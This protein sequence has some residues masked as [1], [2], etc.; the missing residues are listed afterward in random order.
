MFNIFFNT[1]RTAHDPRDRMLAE[2]AD[3]IFEAIQD[4]NLTSHTNGAGGRCV[5][6]PAQYQ[7][8]FYYILSKLSFNL[9]P[10]V[11]DT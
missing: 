1:K 9:N 4:A 3:N 2:L 7:N 10:F 6:V 8:L 11:G 5:H